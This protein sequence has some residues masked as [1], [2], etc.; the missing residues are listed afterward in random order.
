MSDTNFDVHIEITSELAENLNDREL[1]RLIQKMPLV[2][3]AAS[4]LA[5]GMLKGVKKYDSDDNTVLEWLDHAKDE[6]VDLVNYLH[7]LEERYKEQ[8]P[9]GT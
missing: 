1:E 7:L 2:E 5:E 4:R 8:H 6:A 3:E 9:N